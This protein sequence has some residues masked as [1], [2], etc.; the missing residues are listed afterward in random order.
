MSESDKDNLENFFRKRA[1]NHHLEFNEGDWLK[2]E[3]Q[4]DKEMPA[5]PSFWS[6]LK[7]FY[8]I[9][10][11]LIVLPVSWFTFTKINGTGLSNSGSNI[12]R[13]QLIKPED[14][15]LNENAG[16]ITTPSSTGNTGKQKIKESTINA[17]KENIPSSDFVYSNEKIITGIN[18]KPKK[19]IT[20][21]I[22]PENID[23]ASY[24]VFE[25]GA[26]INGQILYSELHFH[27][28]ISPISRLETG[29]VPELIDVTN[30]SE[31]VPE[32]NPT[33]YFSL[34]IGFSPDFSTVGFGNFVTPGSRWTIQA[35]YSFL[36]RLSII[37]G[38]VLVNNKY[39]A[40]GVDYHAPS[41]YWKNGIVA[42]EAYGE[43]KMVDIPLN[44][45]YDILSKPRHKLFV[46]GGASTYFVLKEDYY[47]QY[48][49]DDPDLPDYWGTDEMTVYPFGIVNISVGY[50]YLLGRKGSIQVEPFIKI[51]TTGIG[52]GNVDLHTIG[53][54]FIYKY[55]I[56]K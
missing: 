44:L 27:L 18:T 50:Q 56:G 4:L 53:T 24:A 31:I 11:F 5:T 32:K 23:E 29:D 15:R 42:E 10:L 14:S 45:R 49:Q 26:G 40:Y 7:K 33:S 52:W 47:F 6:L 30:T 41:A 37:T 21:S 8:Y 36:N 35:E 9:P 28:P 51:P 20:S 1:Q 38:I 17:T 39:E 3:A 22:E 46:S 12:T 54:Y 13:T 55:R 19:A 43:C 16:I 34:G 2:M 48:E 25:N